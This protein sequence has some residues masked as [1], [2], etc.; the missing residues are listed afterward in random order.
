MLLAFPNTTG[1]VFALTQEILNNGFAAAAA[2]PRKRIILPV[3]RSD[4]SV[5]QRMLNFM[6][7]GTY[8]MPHLHPLPHA[9]ETIQV[10]H[11]AVGFMV[12]DAD[13]RVLSQHLLRASG[14][15][16]I[17]IEPNV[18]HGFVVLEPD[19]VVLEI[20]RGPYDP[21]HDKV[22]ATWSPKEGEAGATEA[23]KKWEELF[24]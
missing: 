7:P 3:H 18:W 5:V 13:G 2:S 24:R 6:Q 10:L 16:L 22:F 21:V 19:T 12:F 4:D 8:L 20:K 17:D 23:V 15:G 14:L 11:G 9:S 1:P